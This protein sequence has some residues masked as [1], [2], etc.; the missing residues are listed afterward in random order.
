MAAQL[1]PTFKSVLHA[2]AASPG[3]IRSELKFPMPEAAAA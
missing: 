2:A 1:F 3:E